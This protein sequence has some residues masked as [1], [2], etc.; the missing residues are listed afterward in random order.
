MI[1]IMGDNIPRELEDDYYTKAFIDIKKYINEEYDDILKKLDV[2][3]ED[4]PYTHYDFALINANLIKT[5]KNNELLNEKGINKTKYI[6][7]LHVFS[8]IEK[9]YNL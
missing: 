3:I 2:I 4:R 8:Q 6:E 7:M 1:M 5:R 9:D